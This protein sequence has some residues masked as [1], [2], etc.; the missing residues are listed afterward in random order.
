MGV[1]MSVARPAQLMPFS[2]HS[3]C[4][5]RLDH[6][7]YPPTGQFTIVYTRVMRHPLNIH[8]H[9]LTWAGRVDVSIRSRL[10][11]SILPAPAPDA[12][13]PRAPASKAADDHQASEKTPAKRP[14]ARSTPPPPLSRRSH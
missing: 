4:A 3:S 13:A 8:H 12:Q 11:Q 6:M 2:K 10:S 14:Q 7:F 1:L 5:R 9:E